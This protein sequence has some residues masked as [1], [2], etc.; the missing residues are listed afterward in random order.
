MFWVYWVAPFTE[1]CAPYRIIFNLL[2]AS[3]GTSYLAVKF[4]HSVVTLILLTCSGTISLLVS[5][6]VSVPEESKPT[7]V[8]TLESAFA[9]RDRVIV[10]PFNL[11]QSGSFPETIDFIPL[12]PVVSLSFK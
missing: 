3:V 9:H 10:L 7:E 6:S 4:C 1:Y 2:V 8:V 11:A 12:F 5:A